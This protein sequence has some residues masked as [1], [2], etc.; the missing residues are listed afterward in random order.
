MRKETLN[1]SIERDRIEALSR[2]M[3]A[4]VV[5]VI[6]WLTHRSGVAGSVLEHTLM[7][8][9]VLLYVV[10][11]VAIG[12]D[13]WLRPVQR[14]SRNLLAIALDVTG[15]SAG[16]Y[17]GAGTVDPIALFYL[18]IMLGSGMVYG[19]RYLFVA[20][21]LS[22]CGFGFVY[23][24]SDYWQAQPMLSATVAGLMIFLGPYMA[25][26]LGSLE[27]TRLLVTWQADHDGLTSLL[28][29]RAFERELDAVVSGILSHKE[30]FLLYMDLDNFKDIN[31]AAGHAA[32]DQALLDVVQFFV[33]TASDDDVLGRM[34]GDEF[35]LLL[36]DSSTESARRSAEKIRNEVASY[37]LPWGTS[38]YTLGVSVGVASSES[39][40]DGQAL[41]R[42]ADAAC[43][44]SKNNG[45][46]Q[47]H[48]VDANEVDADTQVIRKLQLPE[49]G[50]DGVP[51]RNTAVRQVGRTTRS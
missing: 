51:I 18:W 7:Q 1:Y 45:R 32:G 37:R 2:I 41:I 10:G 47:V 50:P 31:D 23:L 11:S 29:R 27:R 46:N 43:Y 44:A 26:L 49:K 8:Y 14:I 17:L 38:Y 28:N 3:A 25:T 9:G 35:C 24:A 33:E 19:V 21:A 34:G 22:V 40:A 39:V 4:C 20:S 30:H 6:V 15:V 16:L 36:V 42:L 5:A 12:C 48:V 13:L